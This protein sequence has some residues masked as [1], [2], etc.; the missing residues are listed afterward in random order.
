MPK[1]IRTES[2]LSELPSNMNEGR[3]RHSSFE[4][5]TGVPGVKIGESE[6]DPS[7][8]TPMDIDPMSMMGMI[9]GNPYVR[10]VIPSRPIEANIIIHNS[11]NSSR[12][13]IFQVKSNLASTLSSEISRAMPA[14]RDRVNCYI[15]GEES[16]ISSELLRLGVNYL[17]GTENPEVA[18]I[19]T[20]DLCMNGLA[21]VISDFE[22]LALDKTGNR[23]SRT[24]GIKVNH[25]YEV[26]MS[27]LR[28]RRVEIGAG[29]ARSIRAWKAKEFDSFNQSLIDHDQSI[30]NRLQSVGISVARVIANNN[31]V[32]GFSVNNADQEISRVIKRL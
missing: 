5:K 32:Q 18:D 16:E 25:Q 22:E 30:V 10:Q 28:G 13:D 15:V 8:H 26:D 17:D 20:A 7:K 23:F 1:F 27:E 19:T 21:F 31:D 11:P 4:I 2:A 12:S 24:I 3:G 9:T 6:Y 29:G 14:I